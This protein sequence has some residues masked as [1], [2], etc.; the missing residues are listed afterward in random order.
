MGNLPGPGIEPVSPSL[1]GRF[2]STDHHGSP[3]GPVLQHAESSEVTG[4][5]DDCTVMRVFLIPQNG[6]QKNGNF[7]VCDGTT[8]RKE[9]ND[10]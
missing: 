7:C 4:G 10:G 8:V 1:A 6:P 2:C 9:M 5:D 3:A